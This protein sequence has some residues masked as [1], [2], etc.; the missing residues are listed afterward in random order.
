M[1]TSYTCI[2]VHCCCCHRPL[3]GTRTVAKSR[4][5]ARL[6]PNNSGSGARHEMGRPWVDLL[7][8]RVESALKKVRSKFHTRIP[9]ESG[10]RI[11]SPIFYLPW[12]N[13]KELHS[14]RNWNYFRGQSGTWNNSREQSTR[15]HDIRRRLS[16]C[17]CSVPVCVLCIPSYEQIRSAAGDYSL[18]V[19]F[20]S[21]CCGMIETCS[22]LLAATL[23]YSKRKPYDTE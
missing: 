7:D 4:G 2:Y 8:N 21:C 17:C 19:Q 6:C 18:C 9:V 16:L 11:S 14:F 23:R 20:H 22:I 5:S 3:H 12:R 1:Y 15:Y 10:L 13:T